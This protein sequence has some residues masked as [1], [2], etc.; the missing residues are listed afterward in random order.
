MDYMKL[1]YNGFDVVEENTG[2]LPVNDNINAIQM[3]ATDQMI[4]TEAGFLEIFVNNEAQTPV[5]YDNLMVVSRG[6]SLSEVNAY[7]PSGMMITDLSTS[8][9]TQ[10]DFNAYKYNAKEWQKDVKWL[11]YGARL[12]DLV[13]GRVL[14]PDPFVVDGTGSQHFNRYSYVINNPLKYADPS[15]MKI[16]PY[17]ATIENERVPGGGLDRA[18]DPSRSWNTSNSFPYSWTIGGYVNNVTGCAATWGEVSSWLYSNNYIASASYETQ[19]NTLSYLFG[20]SVSNVRYNADKGKIYGQYGY[21]IPG[22]AF[23]PMSGAYDIVLGT[24][25]TV[26]F[27]FYVGNSWQN[28][29]APTQPSGTNLVQGVIGSSPVGG[30]RAPTQKSPIKPDGWSADATIALG[31]IGYT[32]E[33]GKIKGQ[34]FITYGTAAGFEASF[35]LINA[36]YITTP[37]FKNEYFEGRSASLSG[38]IWFFGL[39]IISDHSRGTERDYYFNN[40]GGFRLGGGPGIGASL[41]H[42]KTTLY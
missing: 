41:S 27:S 25:V 23:N 14:S 16:R 11:D 10:A 18:F 30:G 28:S 17:E 38:S 26:G 13:L 35:S 3:L 7:Y 31:P 20:N 33:V 34:W 37:D 40:Y 2:Y 9:G 1:S 21:S 15:C 12:Y 19:I 29:G 6:G 36:I 22:P 39:S 5:Y 8:V 24:S 42:T 32:F 4:M